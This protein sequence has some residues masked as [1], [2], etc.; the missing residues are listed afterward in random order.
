MAY[1][2]AYAIAYAIA[3]AFERV[4]IRAFQCE[5]LPLDVGSPRT[6]YYASPASAIR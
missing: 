4:T 1:A 6:A 2:M 5:V 3:Y